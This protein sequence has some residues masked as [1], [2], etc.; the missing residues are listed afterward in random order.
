MSRRMH[1]TIRRRRPPR[2]SLPIPTSR[3]QVVEV[4]LSRCLRLASRGQG[5][6]DMVFAF[7][8]VFLEAL[9]YSEDLREEEDGSA[10]LFQVL[11]DLI[12]WVRC[13]TVC[14]RV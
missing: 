7:E 10:T 3:V 14:L 9:Q 6:G 2:A 1:P 5:V 4:G 8:N 13:V 12:M 11:V